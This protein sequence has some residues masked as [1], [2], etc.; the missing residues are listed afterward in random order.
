MLLSLP[1]DISTIQR[2]QFLV[3][4]SKYFDIIAKDNDDLGHTIVM[5]HCID[6]GNTVPIRQQPRRVPLPQLSVRKLLDEM[7]AKGIISS[8]KS[9]GA[10]PIVL[11]K[12][13]DESNCFVWTT[14]RSIQ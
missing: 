10:S 11:V 13:K 2:E 14:E 12:K 4:L 6:T 3:L 5:K 1:D 7:L 8:S 9:P